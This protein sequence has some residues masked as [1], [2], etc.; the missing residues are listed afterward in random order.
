MTF[1]EDNQ[2]KKSQNETLNRNILMLILFLLG[3]LLIYGYVI[4][5]NSEDINHHQKLASSN[6]AG[7][8]FIIFI[9]I[10]KYG[11]LLMGIT[12]TITTLTMFIGQK[13]KP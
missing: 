4:I 3:I 7:F 8:R 13:S 1:R 11:I 10:F 6:T 12:F 5:N 9:G 2:E